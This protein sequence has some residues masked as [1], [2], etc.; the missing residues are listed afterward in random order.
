MLV[1]AVFLLFFSPLGFDFTKTGVAHKP[2]DRKFD[3][4]NWRKNSNE[5]FPSTINLMIIG[6]PSGHLSHDFLSFFGV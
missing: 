1:Q 5:N 6:R 4:V 2:A 3:Q